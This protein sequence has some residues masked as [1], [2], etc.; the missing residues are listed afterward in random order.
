MP[1]GMGGILLFILQIYN[2]YYNFKPVSLSTQPNME[3][4]QHGLWETSMP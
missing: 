2:Y 1:F 3:L 4:M